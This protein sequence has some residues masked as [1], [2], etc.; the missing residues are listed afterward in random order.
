MEV[1]TL[2]GSMETTGWILRAGFSIAATASLS[3]PNPE[4]TIPPT[5]GG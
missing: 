4:T 3:V 5:A 2:G 1:L